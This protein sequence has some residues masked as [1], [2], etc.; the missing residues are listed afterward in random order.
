[1][2][3]KYYKNKENEKALQKTM[4]LNINKPNRLKK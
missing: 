3:G 2:Y 4:N 1:M